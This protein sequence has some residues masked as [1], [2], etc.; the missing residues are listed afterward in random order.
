MR[1]TLTAVALQRIIDKGARIAV[2]L[3]SYST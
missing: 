1:V 3:V 2:D